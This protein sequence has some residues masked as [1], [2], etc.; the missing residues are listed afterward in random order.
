MSLPRISVSRLELAPISPETRRKQSRVAPLACAHTH[1]GRAH[2]RAGDARVT[3]CNLIGNP[4]SHYF[5]TSPADGIKRTR[6]PKIIQRAT[7]VHLFL[8]H[9]KKKKFSLTFDTISQQNPSRGY[10]V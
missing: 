4:I 6:E 9:S 2:L 5:K 8:Y 3:A 10:E 7:L 1:P